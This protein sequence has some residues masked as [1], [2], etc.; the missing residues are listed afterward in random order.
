MKI[1]FIK[2]GFII[3]L[4]LLFSA[5]AYAS[6]DVNK[7]DLKKYIVRITSTVPG[8]ALLVAGSYMTLEDGS[9]LV[10][11][12]DKDSQNVTPMEFEVDANFLGGIFYSPFGLKSK[13]DVDRIKV[14]IL[15]KDQTGEHHIL[16][17]TG[18]AV[19]SHVD[20]HGNAY[21]ASGG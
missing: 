19:F 7:Q 8:K 18:W 15:S 2:S 17:G 21:V 12:M 5:V 13:R 14:E 4:A 6:P 16:S 11:T 1:N 10:A 20:A 3:L 9:T